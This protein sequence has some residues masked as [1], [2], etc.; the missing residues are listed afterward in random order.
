M[1]RTTFILAMSQ[2]LNN[3]SF[4]F[5]ENLDARTRQYVTDGYRTSISGTSVCNHDSHCEINEICQAGYCQK[6]K[7]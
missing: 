4:K 3:N 7:R 5:K 6:I 2:I 1:F